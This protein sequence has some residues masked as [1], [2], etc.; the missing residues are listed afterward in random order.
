MSCLLAWLRICPTRQCR[1][2]LI[3]L[4][5]ICV[6]TLW[7]SIHQQLRDEVEF[8][9][10][11]VLNH[12]APQAGWRS[13]C[14]G[15]GLARPAFSSNILSKPPTIKLEPLFYRSWSSQ[16]DIWTIQNKF[17]RSVPSHLPPRLALKVMDNLVLKY[18]AGHIAGYARASH[19]IS[20]RALLSETLLA[21]S[22]HHLSTSIFWPEFMPGRTRKN[23]PCLQYI[24]R[25]TCTST[26][27]P[28]HSSAHPPCMHPVVLKFVRPGTHVRDNYAYL[29]QPP[30]YLVGSLDT[31][32]SFHE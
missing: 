31:L 14:R 21:I 3:F 25:V 13:S 22:H 27:G 9:R 15:R 29:L 12:V 10:P 24:L 16:Y 7:H 8:Y 30:Q 17:T 6:L 32:E 23:G 28:P 26:P 18:F 20:C 4:W 19:K 5:F 1:A 11:A 2:T